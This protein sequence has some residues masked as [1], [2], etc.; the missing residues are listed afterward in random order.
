[1]LRARFNDAR[2]FWDFDQRI[3]L[4]N[5]VEMLKSV[6][7]QKDLGSYWDRIE[8]TK[9]IAKQLAYHPHIVGKEIDLSALTLAV[10]LAKTDL[11]TELVKEFTELQGIVGG[12]YAKKQDQGDAVAEAI[13]CQY[14]PASSD[15]LIPLTIEGQI[16]GLADRMATIADM[17]AVGLEPTGSKDPFALRRAANGV[18]RILAEAGLP[19]SLDQVCRIAANESATS[20]KFETPDETAAFALKLKDFL[21][22]FMKGE[23]L[24]FY[25]R[26]VCG[27]TY[28]V[29]NAVL[30]AGSDNVPD[31]VA[32]AE[33][34]TAVRG[35]DDFAA[36]S[37]AFK[38]MK[39]ILRQAREKSEIVTDSVNASYLGESAERNLFESAEKLASKVEKLRSERAYR[40]A[41]ELIATLRPHVD[42]FFDKVMVMVDD[43]AVRQNRLALIASVLGNFSS[44]ADFSEIVTT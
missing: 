17:F 25:L 23:R 26:D 33:A 15:G 31:A 37:A 41:L 3:P 30:A 4:E 6:T 27:F 5:R 22:N 7:F 32:R 10:E 28:D 18:I 35:S 39:N 13:Y 40:E 16:L 2:F 42:L 34:L 12:L 9:R 1:V 20:T 43:P 29:V 38:R 36:I 8:P 44:I 21:A 24:P 14:Q 19:L 11:T